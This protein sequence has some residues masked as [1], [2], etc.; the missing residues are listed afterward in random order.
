MVNIDLL[1][2]SAM[3]DESERNFPEWA[4]GKMTLKILNDSLPVFVQHFEP[5][6]RT[7][8]RKSSKS[9]F[10]YLLERPIFINGIFNFESSIEIEIF[11]Y[12]LASF[13]SSTEAS[14]P[15]CNPAPDDSLIP[16]H[17]PPVALIRSEL[18]GRSLDY[19][20][21]I[22]VNSGLTEGM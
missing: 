8:R 2:S 14:S 7:E 17:K 22:A 9:D 5:P 16:I 12:L 18:S 3:N 19:L 4:F 21:F 20:C 11:K 6:F 15:R 13:L 10:K 1:D